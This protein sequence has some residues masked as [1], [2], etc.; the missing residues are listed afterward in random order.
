MYCQYTECRIPGWAT[1]TFRLV[2]G[3]LNEWARLDSRLGHELFFSV[4]FGVKKRRIKYRVKKLKTFS[5]LTKEMIKKTMH[6]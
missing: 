6:M 4:G 2:C 5:I 1:S 3:A